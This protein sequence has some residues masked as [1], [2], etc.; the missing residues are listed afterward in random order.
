MEE[1]GG[2]V[3]NYMTILKYIIRHGTDL[4]LFQIDLLFLDTWR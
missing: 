4:G 3:N 1:D 2:E